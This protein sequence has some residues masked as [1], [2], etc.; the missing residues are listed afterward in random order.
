MGCNSSFA[1]DPFDGLLRD[2]AEMLLEGV[3]EHQRRAPLLRIM[4]HEFVQLGFKLRWNG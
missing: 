4:R 3:Q 1:G 2:V